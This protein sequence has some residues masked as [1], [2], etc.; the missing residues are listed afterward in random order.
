LLAKLKLK[1]KNKSKRKS[2]WPGVWNCDCVSV[3]LCATIWS[4]C[5]VRQQNETYATTPHHGQLELWLRLIR[6]QNFETPS[7]KQQKKIIST[8]EL[9]YW[10][11][12][13]PASFKRNR[14]IP[15]KIIIVRQ[16]LHQ[17]MRTA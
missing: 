16:R 17:Q 1:L 7:Q 13:Q 10:T 15:Q 11:N 4:T 3:S 8:F 2:H 14:T 12:T 9:N 5:I 6:C